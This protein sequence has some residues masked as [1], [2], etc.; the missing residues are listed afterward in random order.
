LIYFK[1]QTLKMGFTKQPDEY[2]C[3]PTCVFNALYLLGNAQ[4]TFDEIKQACGTRW[5]NGTDESGLR[6]ALR[7]LGYEG[8]EAQWPHK[9]DNKTATLWLREQHSQNHPVIIC[10]D[11]F[12]H[13]ILVS[14]STEN[15]FIVLDPY[16]GHKG[17]TASR[18]SRTAL[19]KRWWSIDKAK[20]GGLYYGMAVKPRTKIARRMAERHPV[21]Q[22]R[23]IEPLEGRFQRFAAGFAIV[24]RCVRTRT[25]RE[26]TGRLDFRMLAVLQWIGSTIGGPALIGRAF[27]R[28]CAILWLCARPTVTLSAFPARASPD[29]HFRAAGAAYLL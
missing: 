18:Y 8:I 4:V 16:G 20:N 1:K 19:T 9:S 5:W 24:D 3:G 22:P 29:G 26:K 2:S 12:D 7:R 13:W 21:D 15:S 11:N 23:G 10:V 17:A 25:K 14:G 6:R 27:G 28:N